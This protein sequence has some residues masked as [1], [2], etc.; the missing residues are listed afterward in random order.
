MTNEVRNRNCD[1][2]LPGALYVK[3]PKKISWGFLHVSQPI[4]ARQLL[5]LRRVFTDTEYNLVEE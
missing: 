5:A 1:K 4:E 3:I 2:I